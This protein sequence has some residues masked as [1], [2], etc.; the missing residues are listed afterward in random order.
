MDEAPEPPPNGVLIILIIFPLIS[1]CAA[2]SVF[3]G[4]NAAYGDPSVGGFFHNRRIKACGVV[5]ARCAG[6]FYAYRRSNIARVFSRIVPL[7]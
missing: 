7:Y 6:P 2:Y 3:M 1:V 4:N 5:L